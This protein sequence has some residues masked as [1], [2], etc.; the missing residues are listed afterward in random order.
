MSM[1]F[2]ATVTISAPEAS[3]ARAIRSC[4]LNF[5]VPTKSR[6]ENSRPP[7]ISLSISSYFLI[8][9]II[10]HFTFFS[11]PRPCGLH[12]EAPPEGGV[13][14]GVR[15]VNAALRRDASTDTAEIK[16]EKPMRIK[17]YNR[18]DFLYSSMRRS[19]R[20]VASTV[21]SARSSIPESATPATPQ[22]ISGTM[23]SSSIP[24][25]ATIGSV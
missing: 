10:Y 6:D 22:P 20:R 7:M 25:M 17:V 14:G 5:P 16:V 23:S 15:I 12:P 21:S 13:W 19:T 3:M 9:A 4:E 8:S 18:Y 11:F 2:I 24:P 1:R